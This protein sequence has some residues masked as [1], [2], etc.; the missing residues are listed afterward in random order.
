VHDAHGCAL[1]ELRAMIR[2]GGDLALELDLTL[3]G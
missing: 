2:P 1:L 3:P